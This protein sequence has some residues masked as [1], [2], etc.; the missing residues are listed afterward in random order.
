[1]SDEELA[2]LAEQGATKTEVITV[3]GSLIG[4]KEV[5]SPSPIAVVDR[6]RMDS[7]GITNVGDILQKIPSQGNAINSQNNNGGDGSTRIDLRSLGSARTLVLMNGRRLVPSGLGADASVDLG[8]IPLA[9]IERVEVLKD[10][11]SAIYGSDAIAGVVNIITKS[12]FNGSEVTAYTATTQKG[13]GQNYDLSF[14]SGHSSNKGNITFSGGFQ[15]QEPIFAGDRDFSL[16]TYTYNFACTDAAAALPAT[17][18]NHCVQK[19]FTGSPTGVTGKI[20][21]QVTD[22]PVTVPGCSTKF[23]TADGNNGFRNYNLP[24]GDDL[25][26]NYNFQPLN[27]IQTPSQRINLFSNGQYE[28]TKNSSGFFEAQFNSRKS[29]QQLAEEPLVLGDGLMISGANEY[30]PFKQD[31]FGYNR[32][33]VEFG[34]RTFN[35]EINTSRL[36]VGLKGTIPEEVPVL[37]DWRWEASYNY[38]RTDGTQSTHGSIIRSHLANAL[39]PTFTDAAGVVH[40]GTSPDTEIGGGCVPLNILTPG[41]V[42]PEMINYLTFTGTRAGNNQQQTAQAS[43]NGKL[44]DLPNHGDIS[45]AAGVDFRQL[46]GADQPDPLT[47]TGDTTGNQT[48]P[49]S[50]E[51]HAYEGFAELSIVPLSGLEYL[52]WV[53]LDAAARAFKY[54]TFGSGVT[55]KVSGLVRTV[56]GVAVRGTYGNAFRAPN[57]SEL[58]SGQSDSFPSVPD[59]CD[60]VSPDGMPI[61][62]SAKAAAQCKKEGVAVDA[63]SGTSQQRS[64][65]GGNPG[66]KPEHAT[67]GTVGVVYEPISG[68]DFTLDYW[69]IQIN[70]AIA[71][72]PVE[73][74]LGQCYE[75]GVQQ[76][77]D[78]IKRD[79]GTHNLSTITDTI[80][81]VG[82]RSTSGL[83]F[84]G[85]YTYKVNGAGT[86]R[87]AVE[88]TYLFKQNIDTGTVNED[89]SEHI[90]HGR[91]NYDLGVNPALKL[92][93]FTQWAHTSGLSAGVNARYISGFKECKDGCN[94]AEPPVDGMPQILPRDVSAYVTGDLFADY[95]LKNRAGLTKISVGMN[96]VAN[97]KPATIY[98][99]GALNSDESA[100]DF[101][102]RFLY[103]RLSQTF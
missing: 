1:L 95:A 19:T 40:C 101:L 30:N 73:T 52:K 16:K 39:G 88:G 17:D 35:Q 26:D 5:D 37:K 66:L 84:S 7:A 65:V 61:T 93:V 31:I 28:L 41:H 78:L 8:T 4:R 10:G 55:G 44:I 57:I 9:M 100:Y 22:H 34:P 33:L 92:N 91:G 86:F 68:L 81:N 71:T 46:S 42:T 76:F 23:C 89:G 3:T 70:D 47:A 103:L 64:K 14:V 74:I 60:A 27:Y 98:T 43:I 87:H 25:G 11:A 75:G 96:N 32:R 2:K 77:C 49:T 13:D 102:G 83:D 12:N 79:P 82:G 67:V 90:L 72:L 36:V 94:T 51:Y 69:N 20:N 21:T 99:G 18:P 56:G 38:G 59:P 15:N 80:Q 6:E 63:N 97:V 62:L 58:F 24:K 48:A 50:G 85:A 53:E 45:L 29:T 54:N